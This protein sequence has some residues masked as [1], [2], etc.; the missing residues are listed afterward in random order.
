MPAPK[1]QSA[2]EKW[3]TVFDAEKALASLLYVSHALP[4]QRNLY[5]VLKAI[6]RA[7]QAHLESYGRE[8]FHQRYQALEFGAVPALAYDILTLVRDGKSH[9][10]MPKDAKKKISVVKNDTVK[11]LVDAPMNLLSPSDIEC[12]DAA[13]QFY[14]GKDFNWVKTNAHEDPAYKKAYAKKHDSDIPLADIISMDLKNGDVL[15]EHFKA[16]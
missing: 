6:Y 3:W 8:L 15:L 10:N 4:E 11:P 5:K 2:F 1:E 9:G 12:L 14:K 13:I 16:A 7:N